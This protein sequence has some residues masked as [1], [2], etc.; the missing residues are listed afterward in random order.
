MQILRFKNLFKNFKN[1]R[2]IYK[3]FKNLRLQIS[4]IVKWGSCVITS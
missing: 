1:L 3:I 2:L 4:K